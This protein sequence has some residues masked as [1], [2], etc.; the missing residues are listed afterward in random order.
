MAKPFELWGQR[1]LVHIPRGICYNGLV[2]SRDAACP[3]RYPRGWQVSYPER[4]SMTTETVNLDSGSQ[5]SGL[6]ESWGSGH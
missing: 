5:T 3:D 2:P 1:A 4:Y 6:G